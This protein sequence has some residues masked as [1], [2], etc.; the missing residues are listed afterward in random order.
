MIILKNI[1]K[2]YNNKNVLDINNLE[3]NENEVTA[4]VGTSGSGKTT[5]LNILGTLEFPDSGNVNLVKDGEYINIFN[6]IKTYRAKEVGFVFQDFNLIDGLSATDNIKIGCYYSGLNLINT[7]EI[8]KKFRI[9]NY[10]QNVST[11]SG[12]EKQRVSLCRAITKN[13]SI[14]LADEPSGS[15]DSQ[16]ANKVFTSLRNLRHNRHIIIVTH[17]EELAKKFADRIIRLS[18]GK[19]V[20]TYANTPNA[21]DIDNKEQICSLKYAPVKNVSTLKLKASLLLTFNSIK[22]RIWRMLSIIIVIAISI[23][24]LA[25]VININFAGNKISDGLNKSYMETDLIS[26]Y[27]EKQPMLAIGEKPVNMEMLSNLL[28]D[29]QIEEIV[30]GFQDEYYLSENNIISKLSVKLISFTDFFRERISINDI[31]GE[32]PKNEDEIII[33]NTTAYELF[34]G[35]DCIGEVVKLTSGNEASVDV[36]IVGINSTKNVNGEIYTFISYEKATELKNQELK[37]TN[38]IAIEKMRYEIQQG[39]ISSKSAK[40]IYRA[41]VDEDI[42]IRGEVPSYNTEI[43][44][45]AVSSTLF[46][47]LCSTF[48]IDVTSLDAF[49][50][51]CDQDLGFVFNDL[52]K[53]KIT[54]IFQSDNIDIIIDEAVINYLQ[55][56][57]PNNISI[58]ISDINK[59]T[60]I[61]DFIKANGDGLFAISQYEHLRLNVSQNA[62]F[63]QYALIVLGVLLAIMSFFMLHSLIRLT[64]NER[65]KEIAILKSLGATNLNVILTLLLDIL[66]ISIL[67]MVGL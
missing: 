64:V 44:E 42:F 11:L 50:Q 62:R 66:F 39:M 30:P 3:F 48:E 52:H 2:S 6:D 1:S 29:F 47:Y 31:I 9:L 7:D 58:Y 10:K 45:I 18:D 8:L 43:V 60:E 22:R 20:E 61:T 23:A 25:S 34:N 13:A 53:I 40:A 33:S 59:S 67:L 46:Q 36:K 57:L 24:S 65:I 63:F 21:D 28:K 49:E 15:L 14:I 35:E 16:N 26:V 5:L 41:K 55:S 32:I 19:V 17:D 4:I 27:Y 56:P 38:L 54:G 12:G 51:L 37:K